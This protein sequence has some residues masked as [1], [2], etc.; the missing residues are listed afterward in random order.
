MLKLLTNMDTDSN[1]H[2]HTIC[3]LTY[4]ICILLEM[5]W[6]SN[7]LLQCIDLS[8]NLDGYVVFT[9]KNVPAGHIIFYKL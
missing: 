7:H 5:P 4:T 8:S 9:T 3:C 1:D 6:T 2:A